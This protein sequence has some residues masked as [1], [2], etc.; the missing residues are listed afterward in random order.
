MK[1][2]YAILLLAALLCCILA[3]P[4]FATEENGNVF[5][6]SPK[7]FVKTDIFK[8]QN[9]INAKHLLD[10]PTSNAVSP[11][12]ILVSPAKYSQ[13]WLDRTP[14]SWL[15]IMV[16][17]KTANGVDHYHCKVIYDGKYKLIQSNLKSDL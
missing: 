16:V 7:E 10:L 8:I 4:A 15:E 9:A 5:I 6:G 12:A 13:N 1:R 2:A 14:G 17:W 3:V 11:T